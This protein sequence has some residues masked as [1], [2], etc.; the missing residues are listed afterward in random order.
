MSCQ[1]HA[2][3]PKLTGWKLRRYRPRTPVRVDGLQA[4]TSR[5]LEE[6]R[7]LS[8]QGVDVTHCRNTICTRTFDTVVLQSSRKSPSQSA[9]PFEQL[10]RPPT[11]MSE[12]CMAI[13]MS[14][15]VVLLTR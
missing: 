8:H 12:Q 11:Y 1:L 15:L 5:L 7:E 14:V 2:E 13:L 3:H 6:M 4:S 10:L 9:T